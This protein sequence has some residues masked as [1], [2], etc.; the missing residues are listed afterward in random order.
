MMHTNDHKE[1]WETIDGR[2]ERAL[3]PLI[4]RRRSTRSFSEKPVA[5]E[6]LRSILDAARWAPSSSNIQP[7]RFIIVTKEQPQKF[8]LLL[9]LLAEQNKVWAAKAPILILSVAKLT[10]D[11]G[12]R[13][14][15][16][17]LHDVGLASANMTFQAT[18]LGLAVHQMGGFNTEKAKTMLNI[19]ID[20]EPVTMIALGYEDTINHMPQSLRERELLPRVR[21]DLSEITFDGMWDHPWIVTQDQTIKFKTITSN[22]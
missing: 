1:I 16:F 2:W 18:A 22:N 17:A 11:A 13:P 15:K 6:K 12:D 9:N 14:N 5:T 19:P 4:A 8:Q 21:K 7:W 10:N 3:H 20:F